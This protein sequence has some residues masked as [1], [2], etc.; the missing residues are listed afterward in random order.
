MSAF[1]YVVRASVVVHWLPLCGQRHPG[2]VAGCGASVRLQRALPWRAHQQPRCPY[3][4]NALSQTNVE[5]VVSP[6]PH[7]THP[8]P[9]ARPQIA[10]ELIEEA[11]AQLSVYDPAKA[12]P[13]YALAEY[14]RAR[15]N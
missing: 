12:A 7:P 1:A 3:C 11:K 8:H 14:I 4:A 6:H 9:P 15:K 13:L 2:E 10:N 5:S